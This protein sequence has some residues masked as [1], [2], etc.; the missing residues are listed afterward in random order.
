V[1]PTDASKAASGTLVLFASVVDPGASGPRW[2]SV[3]LIPSTGGGGDPST[4][5]QCFAPCVRIRMADDSLKAVGEVAAGD[6][7]RVVRSGSCEQADAA[8]VHVRRD[9]AAAD[10]RGAAGLCA[11]VRLPACWRCR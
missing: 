1:T 4:T 7:V 9:A 5:P 8:V 2:M 3:A 10:E 6:R 11:A